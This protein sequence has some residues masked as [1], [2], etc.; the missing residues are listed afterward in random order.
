[1]RY[2]CERKTCARYSWELNKM[3]RDIYFIIHTH[4]KL[5]A[6]LILHFISRVTVVWC[7]V[8]LDRALISGT[9]YGDKEYLS[10]LCLYM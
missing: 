4:S 10:R 8:Y 6:Y 1:M 7:V 2:S 5:F 9:L 3:S